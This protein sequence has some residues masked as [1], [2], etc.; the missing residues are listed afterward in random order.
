MTSD[1]RPIETPPGDLLSSA[2]LERVI[3]RAAELQTAS[4]SLPDRLDD[5][6]VMRIGLE[7]GLEEQHVNRALLELRAEQLIPSAREDRALPLRL[8][9]KGHVQ[10]SRVVPG[11]ASAVQDKIDH[12]LRSAESLRP[13]RDRPG[14]SVWEPASDLGSQLKRSLDF[15]GHGYELAKAR[16]VEVSVQQLEPGRSLVSLA[17]DLT[18][19]RAEHATGWIVGL[20]LAGVGATVALVLAAGF[21]LLL[22]APVAVTAGLASGSA[23]AARTFRARRERVELVM[24]GVLDRLERGRSLPATRTSIL[25]R[26]S[27]FLDSIE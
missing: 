21:P 24:H 13:M 20:G 18:N 6:E 1:D 14:L 11:E 16:R 26:I 25:E 17:T 19:E 22:A 3:Q 7:V 2:Q 27:G 12:Y 10:A 5:A 23:A 4:E 9:G 15:G 8:W